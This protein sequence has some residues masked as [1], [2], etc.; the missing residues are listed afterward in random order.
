MRGSM[1]NLTQNPNK[2]VDLFMFMGQSNMAG[3]GVTSERWQESAPPLIEGAGYEYRAISDGSRLYEI[4]EPFGVNE[5]KE[6][7][8][9]EPDKKT[10]SMVTAFVNAYYSHN[11]HIPVVGVSASKGGSSISQWQPEGAFL[12]DAVQRLRDCVTFLTANGYHIRHK[13]MLW[14]QGETDGDIATSKEAYFTG[15]SHMLA[16]MKKHGIENLFLVRIGNCNI[17]GCE[18]RYTDMLKWQDELAQTDPDVIMVSTDFAG[19]RE[20]G[21][22]KDSYH[23]YQAAYNEVGTNAGIHTARYV[24]NKLHA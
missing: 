12:T 14:C 13:Y 21:L 23:Y 11:G 3:R 8:I 19:M 10:G 4:T 24:N 2:S 15:F 18:N 20:R 17:P 9:S 16:E 22:M 1:S 5:N 7:G 6:N